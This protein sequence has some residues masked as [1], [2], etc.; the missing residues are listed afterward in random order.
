M[1]LKRKEKIGFNYF[2]LQLSSFCKWDGFLRN[3]WMEENIKKIDQCKP[4]N[5]EFARLLEDDF[6]KMKT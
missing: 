1:P 6:R 4:T 2:I 5:I 3:K